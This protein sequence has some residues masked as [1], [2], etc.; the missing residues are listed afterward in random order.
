MSAIGVVDIAGIGNIGMSGFATM[1]LNAE[2]GFSCFRLWTP[3]QIVASADTGNAAWL[4]SRSI[5]AHGL[6][7]SIRPACRSGSFVLALLAT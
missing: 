3:V 1:S 4:R 5:R 7:R 2:N 6:P